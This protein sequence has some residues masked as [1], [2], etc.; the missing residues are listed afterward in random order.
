MAY[1]HKDTGARIAT[2]RKQYGMTQEQMAEILN[3]SISNLS[4]IERGLQTIPLDLLLDI[5]QFFEV[6]LDYIVIGNTLHT[7]YLRAKIRNIHKL[8]NELERNL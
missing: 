6:S 5:S 4:R 2:L 8:L 1:N 3:I 7:A